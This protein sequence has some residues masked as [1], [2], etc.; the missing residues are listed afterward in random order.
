MAAGF[1]A[2]TGVFAVLA[3]IAEYVYA[4]RTG[5]D[6]HDLRDTL[7]N[8]NVAAGQIVMGT[9]TSGFI[10]AGYAFVHSHRLVELSE[11]MPRW[12][13]LLVGFVLAELLQYWN[14]RISHSWNPLVWGHIT[15]HTSPH[16]N[17]STGMRINWF[18][19]T[20]AW[21]FF[22]P[23]ALLGFSVTEFILFQVVM[24]LYNL[25]MHTRL[26]VDF[27][28]LRYV[29]VTPRSHRLHHSADPAHFGN[30]G[31]SLC[32]WDRLFGTHR[33][34]PADAKLAFGCTNN[35]DAVEPVRINI[36]YLEDIAAHARNSERSFLSVFLSTEAVPA[37]DRPIGRNPQ[38]RHPAALFVP[39]AL[40]AIFVSSIH[41]QLSAAGH[42]F[43][44]LAGM[45]GVLCYGLYLQSNLRSRSETPCPA[46]S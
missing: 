4:R 25:F 43:A 15:H 29:L 13:Y 36:S 6:W 5:R 34:A 33:E 26:D 40:L 42:L 24:N 31:A 17:M 3:T 45:A 35:V 1:F 12:G 38:L 22:T 2:I 46:N 16:M 10:L 14:H 41:P 8:F 27:G 11:H 39:V 37:A 30:Y 32:I 28:P 23:L 20:M 7:A 21:V 44:W 19:R 18:Y 9:L